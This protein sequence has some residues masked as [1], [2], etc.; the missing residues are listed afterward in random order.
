MSVDQVSVAKKAI[1]LIEKYGHEEMIKGL[2]GKS[3]V[4]DIGEFGIVYATPFSGAE[5]FPGVKNYIVSIWYKGKK[6]FNCDYKCMDELDSQKPINK[7]WATEFIAL[8]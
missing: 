8:S 7:D 1:T 2:T 6:V 4:A 3:Q 5:V